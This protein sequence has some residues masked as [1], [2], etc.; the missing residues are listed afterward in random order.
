MP[1]G[2]LNY[3]IPTPDPPRTLPPHLHWIWN[4]SLETSLEVLLSRTPQLSLSSPSTPRLR[5]WSL[6]WYFLSSKISFLNHLSSGLT[7][8]QFLS[9]QLLP[10]NDTL[11]ITNIP[12]F[13]NNGSYS[14]ILSPFQFLPLFWTTVNLH[15]VANNLA[16]HSLTLINGL[17]LHCS[18]IIHHT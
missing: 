2:N 7:Q 12:I 9:F 15:K 14:R 18:L 17:I 10:S 11:L 4:P 5:A 8:N 13:K 3:S 1:F 6:S 16:S